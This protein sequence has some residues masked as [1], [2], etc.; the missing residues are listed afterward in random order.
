MRP[1]DIVVTLAVYT[2]VTCPMNG[3]AYGTRKEK[4]RTKRALVIV[5][6]GGA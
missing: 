5:L 6:I 1:N 2:T 3:R 4:A